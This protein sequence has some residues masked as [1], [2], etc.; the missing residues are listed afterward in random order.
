MLQRFYSTFR[1]QEILKYN[2][3]FSFRVLYKIYPILSDKMNAYVIAASSMAME[4]EDLAN[5]H[6]YSQH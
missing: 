4:T 3:L 5:S 6:K 1:A 2:M